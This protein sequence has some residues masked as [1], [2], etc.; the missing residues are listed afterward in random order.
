MKNP[1][2]STQF[3]NYFGRL[4]AT[5]TYLSLEGVRSLFLTTLVKEWEK[6]EAFLAKD[7]HQHHL[8][9]NFPLIFAHF[10]E[11]ATWLY[12][13]SFGAAISSCNTKVLI[14]QLKQQKLFKSFV[15]N[16]LVFLSENEW[17]FGLPKSRTQFLSH[18]FC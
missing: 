3:S 4:Q 18:S 14:F 5:F 17:G 13:L 6:N 1:F 16:A 11:K 10:S 12:L 7:Q 2:N 8:D 15:Q 9:L